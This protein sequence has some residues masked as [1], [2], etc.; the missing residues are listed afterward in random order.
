[1]CAHKEKGIRGR[2]MIELRE[3]ETHKLRLRK[4]RE[5]CERLKTYGV[6]SQSLEG[7][8]L[9]IKMEG[10]MGKGGEKEEEEK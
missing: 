8:Q 2:R 6:I 7:L 3:C 4:M 9:S 1:M 5:E 10:L